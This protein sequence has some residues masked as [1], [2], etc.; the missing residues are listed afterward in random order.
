MAKLNNAGYQVEFEC[1]D[2]GKFFTLEDL[3][4][5]SPGGDRLCN[6]CFK[7]FKMTLVKERAKAL[8]MEDLIRVGR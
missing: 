4:Y 3:H 1:S 5:M 8:G 6:K 2:C 7:K